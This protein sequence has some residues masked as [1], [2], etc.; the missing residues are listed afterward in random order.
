MSRPLACSLP[1][2]SRGDNHLSVVGRLACSRVL[3][4]D[5]R[6][7][8]LASSAPHLSGGLQSDEHGVAVQKAT[9]S[10]AE[11]NRQLTASLSAKVGSFKG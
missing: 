4:L 11:E 2:S 8:L 1:G 3:P 10:L 9:R 5:V 7:R 6:L